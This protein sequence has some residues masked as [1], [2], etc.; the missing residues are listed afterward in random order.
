LP[1]E[2]RVVEGARGLANND[3]RGV[4][5]ELLDA[6][7][8]DV[9]GG[10]YWTCAAISAKRLEPDDRARARVAFGGAPTRAH[11]TADV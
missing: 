5:R 10:A 7:Q 8:H 9:E 1:G 2:G 6:A 4:D 3:R 11:A